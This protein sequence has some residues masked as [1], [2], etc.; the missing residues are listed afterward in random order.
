MVFRKDICGI[1][2]IGI[3]YIAVSYASYATSYHMILGAMA[4]R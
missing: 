1:I 2:C 4:E 3:T